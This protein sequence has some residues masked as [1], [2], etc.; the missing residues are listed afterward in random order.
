MPKLPRINSRRM[1]GAL[2]R[3]GYVFRRQTGGHVILR[4]PDTGRVVAVPE[5]PGFMGPDLVPSILR[6]AGL[7]ADDLI[8][9]L[10]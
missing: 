2:Q 10:R 8:E 7:K 1:I 9:L 4:H 5:H 3:A 6:Q